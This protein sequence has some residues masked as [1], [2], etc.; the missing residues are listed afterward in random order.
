MFFPVLAIILLIVLLPLALAGISFAPWVP[1][2]KEDI[3]RAFRLAKLQPGETIYDLG[4]GDGKA[5]FIAAQQFRANGVGVEIAW[6]LWLWSQL[7]RLWSKGNTRFILG[8]LFATPIGDADVVYIFGMPDKIKDKLRLKLERELKPGAR[9]LSY[10]FAI[11]DWT[12]VVRDK[13]AGKLSIYLY[14]R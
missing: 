14:Q 5:I 2:W 4:S 10:S 13:P 3:E 7:R 11:P 8:N 9:V 12:P 6:P 1:T